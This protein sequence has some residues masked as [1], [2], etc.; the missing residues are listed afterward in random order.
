MDI[1]PLIY[2]LKYYVHGS[3]CTECFE[4]NEKSLKMLTHI[5]TLAESPF[6]KG[7]IEYQLYKADATTKQK[8]ILV[9]PYVIK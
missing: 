3:K 9:L 5:S 7:V 2:D 6:G 4:Q 1:I 8:L